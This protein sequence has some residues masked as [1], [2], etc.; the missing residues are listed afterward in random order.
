MAAHRTKPDKRGSS[1]SHIPV[2]QEHLTEQAILE[3]LI[4]P[5][6]STASDSHKKERKDKLRETYLRFHPDK[7]EG[8]FMD[9]VKE[10][11]KGAV[12]EAIGQVVCSLN[13]LM[14]EKA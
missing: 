11:E 4:P 9:L 1:T 7:F 14:S 8:R 10:K 12:R 3:F 13:S 2:S 6:P 5:T